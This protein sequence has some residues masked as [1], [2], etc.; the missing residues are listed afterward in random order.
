MN[1]ITVGLIGFGTVGT[2]VARLLTER[3]GLLTHRLGVPLVLK[4]VAD[5]DLE[6]PRE[7]SLEPGLLT[8]HNQEIL[9]D[10]DIDIVAELIGGTEAAY[11]SFWPCVRG[12]PPTA[13]RRSWGYS[14]A[15]PITS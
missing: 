14:T 8:R 11:P 15:R 5:I 10:P 7:V 13:F 1:A 6:R 4:K 9:D 3:L 2:G 12:W